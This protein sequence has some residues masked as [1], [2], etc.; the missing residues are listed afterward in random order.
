M[1]R[2]SAEA[3]RSGSASAVSAE[4]EADGGEVEDTDDGD[5]GA[6]ASWELDGSCLLQALPS[7]VRAIAKEAPLAP[8]MSDC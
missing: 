1:A 3:E 2:A 8:R 6:D 7:S 5:A 4:D